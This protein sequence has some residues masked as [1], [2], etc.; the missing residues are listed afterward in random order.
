M[1]SRRSTQLSAAWRLDW[2]PQAMR[3]PCKGACL[4]SLKSICVSC[5]G[6]LAHLSAGTWLR[7]GRGATSTSKLRCSCSYIVC[8]ASNV[9]CQLC[10]AGRDFH[11]SGS[12][13]PVHAVSLVVQ[14]LI[15][16]WLIPGCHETCLLRCNRP[17]RS[18]QR[19][20][21]KPPDIIA[22]RVPGLPCS[23]GVRE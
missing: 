22:A 23:A 11:A 2:P 20:C 3:H 8:I 19:V 6:F 21:S 13:A 7:S 18:M 10:A 5:H 12:K 17:H 4:R 1:I 16:L 9:H 15:E 14:A